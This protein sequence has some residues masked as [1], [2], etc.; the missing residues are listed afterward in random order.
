MNLRL[1][2]FLADA[3]VSSR[4]GGE[5]LI[6]N[7]HVQVNGRIVREL[8]T[9]VDADHDTVCVDGRPVKIRRKLYVALNKPA[10][11]LCTRSDP[12]KR[13]CVGDLLPKE[14]NTLYP[15]GRLDYDSDGLLFL[16]NDGDFC[17]RLTHPRFGIRKKYLAIVAGKV[18]DSVLKKLVH[19]VEHEGELLKPTRV[20]CLLRNNSH[21]HVEIELA[22]GKNRE[23]RRLF[24]A[25]GFEVER[26]QR[27]Q[28]GSIK[29]GEL[30]P[31]KWRTLTAPEIK[32]LMP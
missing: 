22:E 27:I 2:K 31:G 32:S 29:L 15:V 12:Q 14:W 13:S 6:L 17:L 21:T 1:Q 19:G 3:G 24:S 18:E 11:F 23:V 8:G 26:L 25:V 5:E 4:R 9:K 7:G 30:P 16:T 10:G 20:H 28:I